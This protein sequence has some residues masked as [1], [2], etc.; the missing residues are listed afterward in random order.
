MDY[1]REYGARAG[2]ERHRKARRGKREVAL[3]AGDEAERPDHQIGVSFVRHAELRGPA[4]CVGVLR[5]VVI[6]G[7]VA[8]DDRTVVLHADARSDAVVGREAPRAALSD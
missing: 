7:D 8:E 3:L 1:D 6:A 4:L 2:A 5:V